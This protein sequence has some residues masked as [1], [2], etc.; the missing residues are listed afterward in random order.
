MIFLM[1]ADL[2]TDIWISEDETFTVFQE[3]LLLPL[4]SQRYYRNQPF[5][6]TNVREGS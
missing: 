3:H 1:A 5:Y 4:S 2:L 6:V